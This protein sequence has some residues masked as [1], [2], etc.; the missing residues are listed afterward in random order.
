MQQ[1]T[2]S[3]TITVPPG[4]IPPAPFTFP[5]PLIGQAFSFQ[6]PLPTGGVP[7]YVFSDPSSSLPTGLTVSPSGLVTG[8]P[9]A[10]GT[11]NTNILVKDSSP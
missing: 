7:P 8:T 11:F 9:T 4:M 3:L 2:Y 6:L 5:T 1:L 10:A